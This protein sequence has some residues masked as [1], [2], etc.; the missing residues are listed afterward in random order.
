MTPDAQNIMESADPRRL[1]L[2]FSQATS[3]WM[4]RAPLVKVLLI[5]LSVYFLTD[6][7]P[8]ILNSSLVNTRGVSPLSLPVNDSVR[9]AFLLVARISEIL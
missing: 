9:M 6:V 4:P 2:S 3:Q 5:V 7:C 8:T 1:T